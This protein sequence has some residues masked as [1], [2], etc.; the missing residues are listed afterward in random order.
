MGIL[1]WIAFFTIVRL[2]NSDTVDVKEKL[3]SDL[4]AIQKELDGMQGST[5]DLKESLNAFSNGLDEYIKK[6]DSAATFDRRV[7]AANEI[8]EA[9]LKAVP[10]FRSGEPGQVI[11]GVLDMTSVALTTFGGR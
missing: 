10:K 4:S 2:T 9:T 8:V 5:D 3:R 11:S 6:E 7:D 1:P